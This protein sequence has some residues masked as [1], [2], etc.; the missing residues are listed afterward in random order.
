MTSTSSVQDKIQIFINSHPEYEG[1]PLS[2]ISSELVSA[3]VLTT[4]ELG[5]LD[6]TSTFSIANKTPQKDDNVDSFEHAENTDASQATETTETI[7]EHGNEVI[8]K[9]KG[10]ELVEKVIKE[11]IPNSEEVKTITITYSK[12]KPFTKKVQSGDEVLET[13][14]YTSETLENGEEVV[15]IKTM[16]GDGKSVEQTIAKKVDENG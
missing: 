16:N 13:S 9:K 7:I 8:V 4:E 11:K 12:G 1:K 2:E 10:D 5:T 14:L 15:A 3:G 6:S